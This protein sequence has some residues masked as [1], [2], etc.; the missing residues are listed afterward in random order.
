MDLE[1]LAVIILP[2]AFSAPQ[3]ERAIRQG[4]DGGRKVRGQFEQFAALGNVTALFDGLA[5]TVPVS[6][7]SSSRKAG[8]CR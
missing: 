8:D 6:V 7:K 3:F 1:I 2:G 4:Q 5:V